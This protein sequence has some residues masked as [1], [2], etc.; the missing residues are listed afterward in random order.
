MAIS[1]KQQLSNLPSAL[2]SF[3]G[4]GRELLE[5][6]Q[7]LATTRLLTLTGPGGCGKTRLALAV[8]NELV[9]QFEDG[10][11]LTEFAPLTDAS[12]VPQA[13]ASVSGIHEQAGRSLTET[14]SNQL[15]G[16]QTLLIF[17]NCE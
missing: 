3:V 14:L 2:S 10:V 12:L 11:W 6:Q 9:L 7:L 17:D 13:V 8:A 16:R 4:R 15:K 1:D 5:V